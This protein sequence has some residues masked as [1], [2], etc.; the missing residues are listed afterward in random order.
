MILT[1]SGKPKPVP[2]GLL[3]A[4]RVNASRCT[5]ED[6]PHPESDTLTVTSAPWT[7]AL[8]SIGFRES[9]SRYDSI[10]FIKILVRASISFPPGLYETLEE[11]AKKKKVS[12]AWVVRDA[13]EKYV[14]ENGTLLRGK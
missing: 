13:A 2:L 9:I 10:A 7:S 3:V 5:S 12:L 11:I 14:T 4:K 6:M 8:I 1:A